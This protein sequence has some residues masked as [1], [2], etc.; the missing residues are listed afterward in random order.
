MR[1]IGGRGRITRDAAMSAYTSFLKA[2][3]HAELFLS[4]LE[5]AARLTTYEVPATADGARPIATPEEML[6]AAITREDIGKSL[7][8]L[9][10]MNLEI[11]QVT[12][13]YKRCFSDGRKPVLYASAHELVCVIHAELG[14]ALSR[15]RANKSFFLEVTPDLLE[16]LGIDLADVTL[17]LR[18]ERADLRLAQMHAPSSVLAL[19]AG[20]FTLD[21]KFFRLTGRARDLLEALLKARHHRAT[22]DQLREAMRIEDVEVTYPEQVIKDAAKDL[23]A[24][25]KNAV[26]E[27]R[28]S[29]PEDPLPSTGQLKDLAYELHQLFF[30][31][32]SK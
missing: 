11:A 3:V 26:T 7:A 2:S 25:L 28:G 21:D 6:E 18:A 9:L 1:G 31:I 27:T 24:A 23:R 32:N 30:E 5:E 4:I 20:G 8:E 17:S 29:Y 10:R 14:I 22:V 19:V 15:A 16:R 13:G 12:G